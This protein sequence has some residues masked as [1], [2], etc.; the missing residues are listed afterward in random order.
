LLPVDSAQTPTSCL[1]C[2]VSAGIDTF[3]G[4]LGKSNFESLLN[5]LQNLLVLLGAHKGHSKTLGTETTG[6]TDS[7]EVRAGVVGKVV[8]D[9]QVDTLDVD[10]TAE[11]VSG[12]TDA[13][14]ELLELLVATDTFF[15]AD[16]RVDGDRG[17]VA[18]AEKLVQLSGT[19]GAPDKNDDLVELEVI[20]KLVELAVLLLLLKLDVVLLKTVEGELRILIHVVLSR[21]L[22]KLLAD[23]LDGLGQGGREHHNLLL[24]RSG[25]EHILDIG[26]H[27]RLVEHLVA[28]IK[29]ENADTAK[30]E[31]LVADESLKT[32]GGTDND[33]GASVLVLQGLHVGLDGS[34]TVEDASL[35][36]GH[37]LAETVVLVAN[38]VGELT[39]VA[40]DHDGN[41]AVDGLDLLQGGQDEHGRLSETRLGLAD[42]VATKESLRDTGLLDCRS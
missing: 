30:S 7:V 42:D 31:G 24:L 13:L 15:L 32:S 36:V 9:G 34:T 18:L 35:D 29:N 4:E 23:G 40:H 27:V 21:V 20:E 39:S 38:L 10:T 8:V 12:N 33:V 19:S 25:T 26:A 17:E 11:N 1:G 14:L 37:V 41:L 6:T 22:H 3:L 2:H 28:F 5:L 16:A